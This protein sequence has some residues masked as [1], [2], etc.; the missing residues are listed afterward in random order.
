MSSYENGALFKSIHR[1]SY[2]CNKAPGGVVYGQY[3][4]AKGLR[5]VLDTALSRGILTIYHKPPKC[6]IAIIAIPPYRS[7]LVNIAAP[8]RSTRSSRYI[9]LVTPKTNSY[10]GRL[11][12][13]FSAANA[14]NELQK[15]LKLETLTSLISFQDQRPEQRT[16]HCT[17]K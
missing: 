13:Q 6:L 12:F 15:S 7:S 4:T 17:C 8:T 10:F 1:W 16:D 14:W 5:A 2:L 9:S 11:T 3:T